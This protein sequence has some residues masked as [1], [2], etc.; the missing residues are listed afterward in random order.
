[1][2]LLMAPG[3]WKLGFNGLSGVEWQALMPLIHVTDH[4]DRVP[5]LLRQVEA[6]VLNA[7]RKQASQK[8]QTERDLAE[9]R[10]TDPKAANLKSYDLI[11]L[12]NEVFANG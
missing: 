9:I 4:R 11:D 8:A 7:Y 5:G 3:L 12:E 1:M 10:K 6:M 2:F